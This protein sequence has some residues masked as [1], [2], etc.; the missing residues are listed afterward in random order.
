MDRRK[1]EE[2]YKMRKN[3]SVKMPQDIDFYV[4]EA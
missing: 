4:G 3:V 1:Q 2:R